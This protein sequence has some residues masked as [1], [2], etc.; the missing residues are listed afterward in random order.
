MKNAYDEMFFQ[1]LRI[2]LAEER[3][4]ELY[5]SDKIQSPVHL[6]IGQEAV[7]VGACRG[8]KTDDLLFSSYRGHA[9]YL[10]KGGGLKAMFAEL[11]GK[12]SGC[13][14]GKAGSMH[15]LAPEVGMLVSSA[16]VASTIPH[17]VG[18]ALAAKMRGTGQVAVAAFGDGATD[19]GVYH[20][21]LNFAALR[22]VPV[23]FLCENNGLAVHTPAAARQSYRIADHA[24]TYGLPVTVVAEG[25]DFVKV[26]EVFSGLVS[27]ARKTGAPQFV[28]I[29]T[30]RYK[31]H[32]GPG[33]DWHAGYRRPEDLERWKAK[34]P[35]VQDRAAVERHRPAILKEIDEAVAFAERSPW[36][37]AEELVADVD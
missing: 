32:V 21:S 31:E 15:L 17:A 27:A 25:W 4:V 26:H 16:V 28:E 33:D 19:E 37:G 36:P 7:A 8:L 14:K 11:Y 5:P 23:V 22:K 6:S 24:R 3:I 18:A 10:A 1:A 34:D 2:R 12:A 29:H 9:F 13:G 20:E 35:L 30:F